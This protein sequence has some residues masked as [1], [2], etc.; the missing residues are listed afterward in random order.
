ML[1]LESAQA[2]E[3]GWAGVEGILESLDEQN[4]S[5]KLWCTIGAQKSANKVIF[6]E[7]QHLKLLKIREKRWTQ[8]GQIELAN[9]RLQPLGHLSGV[10]FQ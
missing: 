5:R 2:M 6:C 10:L 9:R 4:S 3:R 8:A 1:H 7:L